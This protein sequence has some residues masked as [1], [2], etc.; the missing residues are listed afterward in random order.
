LQVLEREKEVF[1]SNPKMQPNLEKYA[2][3]RAT[4]KAEARTDIVFDL[5]EAGV[6]QP[7]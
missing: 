3:R 6:N 7:L 2:I 1:L 4:I 5:A